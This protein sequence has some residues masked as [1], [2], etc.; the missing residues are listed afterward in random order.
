M[1]K[2]LSILMAQFG[3]GSVLALVLGITLAISARASVIYTDFGT[4]ICG[5]NPTCIANNGINQNTDGLA[6]ATAPFGDLEMA[7]NG[8]TPVGSFTLSDVQL[9]IASFAPLATNTANVYLMATSGGVPGAV[10]ESWLGVLPEATA[11]PQLNA[12]TL[13]SAAHPTLSSGTEYWLAVG[14]AT[15]TSFV[16]WYYS[17]TVTSSA[18]NL[19]E[20]T[21]NGGAGIPTPAG[22]WNPYNS[23]EVLQNAFQ[24]DGTPIQTGGAPEPSS[25]ALLS[26]GLLLLALRKFAR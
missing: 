14:P 5:G 8:F 4:G 21:T 7:A 18:S 10:L 20:N 9:V 26:T 25:V 11:T 2:Q 17:W 24:I 1:R 19:R 6:G 22:P 12:I 16:G 23:L 3:R 15:S 13:T